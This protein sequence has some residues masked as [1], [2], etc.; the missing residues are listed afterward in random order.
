MERTMARSYQRYCPIAHAL[1]TVGE[2]WSLLVVREL[3]HGPLRYTDLLERLQGCGTNILAAR[4]RQLEASGVVQKRRLPPPAA[5]TVYELTEYGEGL[6]PAL[7]ELAW[8]GARSIGPPVG[9]ELEPGWLVH[10]LETIGAPPETTP[11]F[12]LR[13]GD[14]IAGLAQ[15]KVVD[16]PISDPDVVVSGDATGFYYLMIERRTDGLDVTGS[17][18]DL[19]CVLD[20]IGAPGRASPAAS[21]HDAASLA[22]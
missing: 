6:R 16:G 2:R 17:L 15:G 7:R 11:S 18:D 14:E 1:D 13:I 5:S 21:G 19:E 10:A 9:R 4:L 22:P 3:T 20:G 8:W 12:E